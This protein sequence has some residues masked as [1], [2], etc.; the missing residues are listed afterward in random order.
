MTENRE[1][2]CAKC[3]RKITAADINCPLCGALTAPG[4][5]EPKSRVAYVLL[6]FFFGWA[7]IHN[8]YAK[9]TGEGLVQLGVTLLSCGL[10]LWAV[11]LW[12]LIEMFTVSRDGRNVPMRGRGILTA[13]ILL[14]AGALL[15]FGAVGYP[16][17]LRC[18]QEAALTGCREHLSRIGAALLLYADENGGA[19]PAADGIPGFEALPLAEA[20]VWVCPSG[21]EQVDFRRLSRRNCSY[22]YLGGANREQAEC[23]VAFEL[24]GNHARNRVNILYADGRVETHVFPGSVRSDVEV[25]G[26]LAD[27][28]PDPE[29]KAFLL[30]KR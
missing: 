28:E 7:G 19:F 17:Y 26:A 13:A 29:L 8:F 16:F 3:G 18:R 22:V 6:A 15:F 9:R 27:L 4:R 11:E 24:P 12:V 1:S 23:P 25:I 21:S 2:T 10:M 5:L 14:A 30:R 20:E